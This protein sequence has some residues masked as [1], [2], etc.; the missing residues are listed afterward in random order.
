MK[1]FWLRVFSLFGWKSQPVPTVEEPTDW[2]PS[3]PEQVEEETVRRCFSS[4]RPFL[5]SI[6]E[7][8]KVEFKQL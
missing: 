4:G 2:R 7:D 6:S 5:A 1:N 3:L 8:G